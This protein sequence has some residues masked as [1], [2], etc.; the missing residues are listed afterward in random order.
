MTA[1]EGKELVR[2]LLARMK[3]R[4]LDALN[5]QSLRQEQV[6]I[7]QEIEWMMLAIGRLFDE[8]ELGELEETFQDFKRTY[9]LGDRGIM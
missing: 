1:G 6:S 8:D 9:R 4:G 7:G 2:E 3:A 5:Q